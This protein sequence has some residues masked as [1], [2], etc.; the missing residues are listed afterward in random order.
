MLISKAEAG[1]HIAIAN[2]GSSSI[3]PD[4]KFPSSKRAS[5]SNCTDLNKWHVVS[6]TWSYKKENLSNCLSNGEKLMISRR[7][8]FRAPITAI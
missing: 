3:E 5:K 6:V 7:V 1:A 4:L 8:T 2:D